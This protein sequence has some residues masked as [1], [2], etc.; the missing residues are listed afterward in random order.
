MEEIRMTDE[1]WNFYDN[2]LD[3]WA[4]RIIETP[5]DRR[6]YI[7]MLKTLLEEKDFILN[8]LVFF[9]TANIHKLYERITIRRDNFLTL[10][11]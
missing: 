8:F 4:N 11:M 9:D 5:E 6:E 10:L 7:L 3:K 1:K 2:M